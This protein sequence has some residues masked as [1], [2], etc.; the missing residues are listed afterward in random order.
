M[1]TNPEP[2]VKPAPKLDKVAI[3]KAVSG[4]LLLFA[5]WAVDHQSAVITFIALLVVWSINV[6][7]KYFNRK[8]GTAWLTTAL[9]V[10]AIVL[11]LLFS[12]VALP[13]FPVFD[14]DPQVYSTALIDFAGVIL[15]LAAPT[16]ASATGIYN[17]LLKT[18]FDKIADKITE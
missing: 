16:V 15:S 2:F 8:V 18:V 6:V 7:F 4:V 9:Y 12:P 5:A 11:A 1:N 3:T 17:I 14:G 13:A 10:I